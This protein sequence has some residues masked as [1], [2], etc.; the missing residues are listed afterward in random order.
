MIIIFWNPINLVKVIRKAKEILFSQW[1][2]I[3]MIYLHSNH[4]KY[5]KTLKKV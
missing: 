5:L 1:K 3:G 2:L 4:K